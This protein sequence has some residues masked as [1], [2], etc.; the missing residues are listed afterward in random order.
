MVDTLGCGG[1]ATLLQDLGH[2]VADACG[3]AIVPRIRT[4]RGAGGDWS[5]SAKVIRIGARELSAYPDRL[6]HVIAHELAHAQAEAREGHSPKFWNRLAQG[7]KKAGRLELLRYDI[8]YKEGALRVARQYSLPNL[9]PREGFSFEVGKVISDS[10]R[11]RWVIERRFRRGGAPHYRLES[12]GWVWT[13][14]EEQLI[15]QAR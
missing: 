5:R 9:P 4:R 14:S 10:K 1:S 15:R 3:F 11:R 7:L 6:W 8:G 2:V 13:T 12:P